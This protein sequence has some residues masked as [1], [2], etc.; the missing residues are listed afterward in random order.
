MR[1]KLASSYLTQANWLLPISGT[2]RTWLRHDAL[3]GNFSAYLLLVVPYP[4]LREL[5]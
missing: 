2:L 3:T 1:D 4:Q 5:G